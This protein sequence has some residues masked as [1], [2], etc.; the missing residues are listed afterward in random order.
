MKL[1][2]DIDN[3]FKRATAN[4]LWLKENKSKA[5]IIV[6]V[7]LLSNL[8]PPLIVGDSSIA[9][10]QCAKN[11]GI[12]FKSQV[13]WPN[14]VNTICGK[15]YVMWRYLCMTQSFT[16]F[17][18]RMLLAKAYIIPILLYG[19]ELSASMDS[20][21]VTYNNVARYSIVVYVYRSRYSIISLFSY[22]RLS[23]Y[24]RE[25]NYLFS[26]L[27]FSRTKA[28]RCRKQLS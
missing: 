21:N 27:Q 15:T 25:P 13:S 17:N 18:I 2:Q 14:H 6:K 12:I 24:V 11:L 26:R 8:L 7:F 1:N 3:I 22:T 10:A 28:I 19:C 5:I 4:G 20:V 9:L 16:P 23:M